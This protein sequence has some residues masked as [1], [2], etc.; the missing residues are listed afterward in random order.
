MS[1]ID[2]AAMRTR[3]RISEERA[4][5]RGAKRAAEMHM[6]T[7]DVRTLLDAAEALERVRALCDRYE[8]SAFEPL[9]LEVR[10]AAALP[11]KVTT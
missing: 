9:I 4:R 2:I 7:R 1:D 11:E 10:A 3:C 5:R 8:R 6:H